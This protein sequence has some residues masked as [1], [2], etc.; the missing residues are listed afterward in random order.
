MLCACEHVQYHDYQHCIVSQF[1][2]ETIRLTLTTWFFERREAA[3]KHKH[4]VT[5][6]VV[7]K[8]VS[9]LEAALL[10]NVYQVD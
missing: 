1:Y 3:A 6:K 10:L 8:L 2:V 7:K 5:P 9:M 4:L